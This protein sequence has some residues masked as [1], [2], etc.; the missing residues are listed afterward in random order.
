MAIST[1]EVHGRGV[2]RL[3]LSAPV[4][5]QHA[6]FVFRQETFPGLSS[7]YLLRTSPATRARRVY[8]SLLGRN[9]PCQL[10]FAAPSNW[11]SL[12]QLL[13]SLPICRFTRNPQARTRSPPP[14]PSS[15]PPTLPSRT[16]PKQIPPSPTLPNRI[17]HRPTSRSRT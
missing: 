12:R 13:S 9:P 15:P 14:R 7:S 2:N 5:T 4:P 16:L 3:F 17:R 6:Q 11:L 8:T 10:F 1:L